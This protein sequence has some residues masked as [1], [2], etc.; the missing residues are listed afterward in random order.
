MK[1]P[2]ILRKRY[3]PF[4]TVDISGDELISRSD[5]LIV[6]RWKP[7]KSRSDISGGISY[8]FLKEGYKVSKFLGPSGEFKYWYCDLINVDYDEKLD[9]YVLTDLLVDVKIMPDGS[10]MVLDVDE[11]AEAME[12]G[13]ITKEEACTALR[14][15]A[16]VLEMAYNGNFPPSV[17]LE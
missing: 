5:D 11:V 13:L 2:T 17:C 16:K 15:L 1:K 9:K 4:E 6:T 3:I 12:K 7:I 14:T 8:T 10:V